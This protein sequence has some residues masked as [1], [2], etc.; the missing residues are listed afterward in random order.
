MLPLMVIILF[1]MFEGGY[2]L[3]NEHK[4][5]KGVRDGARYAARQ[6]FT[7]FPCTGST[8]TDATLLANIQNVTRTG[9]ADGTGQEYIPG[10]TN[11]DITVSYDCDGTTTTG[12]YKSVDGGAPRVTVAADVDYTPLW[13]VIGFDASSLSLKAEAQAAVM[14]L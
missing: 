10:W 12:L 8:I 14:G 6:P 4:A 13:G 1:G 5:L 2:F 9:T 3:Y 11:G 7:N